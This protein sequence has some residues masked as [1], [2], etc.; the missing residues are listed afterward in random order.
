MMPGFPT[1][2]WRNLEAARKEQVADHFFL[3][4]KISLNSR[5]YGNNANMVGGIRS[6][7]LLSFFRVLKTFIIM[8]L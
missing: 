6:A 4:E 5:D 8:H 2:V 3:P 7:D 1:R